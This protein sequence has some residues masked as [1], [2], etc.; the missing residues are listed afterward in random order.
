MDTKKILVNEREAAELLGIKP[1]TLRVWRCLHTGPAYF[2]LHGKTIRYDRD[3]VSAW[4]ES[5]AVTPDGAP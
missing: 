1:S 4:I 5:Q 3:A 2:K